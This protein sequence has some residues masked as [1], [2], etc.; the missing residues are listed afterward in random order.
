MQ[1]PKQDPAPRIQML[2]RPKEAQKKPETF[3]FKPWRIPAVSVMRRI[4]GDSE[5]GVSKELVSICSI[6][7]CFIHGASQF[8]LVTFC[9]SSEAVCSDRQRGRMTEQRWGRVE[10]S[11]EHD[12]G[13]KAGDT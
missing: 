12:G 2:R 6:C 10:L 8:L 13:M 9:D 4:L 1:V 3:S 5:S 7:F 11:L